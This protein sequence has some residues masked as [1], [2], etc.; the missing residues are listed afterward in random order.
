MGVWERP[1]AG[2]PSGLFP[3]GVSVGE[4]MK[5]CWSSV[6]NPLVGEAR[7]ALLAI[8]LRRGLDDASV[9]PGL[10]VLLKL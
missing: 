8:S 2:L 7:A 1:A 10:V 3:I 4:I 9:V 5:K 6:L